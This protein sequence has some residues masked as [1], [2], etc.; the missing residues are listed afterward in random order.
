[1]PKMT[2]SHLEASILLALLASVVMGVVTKR[3]D[4]ERLSYG[5]YCFVCFIGSLFGL[6]WLMYFGHR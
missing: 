5:L 3:T 2:L 4:R 6:G 1:M